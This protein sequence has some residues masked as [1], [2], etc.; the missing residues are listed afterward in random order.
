MSALAPRILFDNPDLSALAAPAFLLADLLAG[1]FPRKKARPWEDVD[2][3]LAE[4]TRQLDHLA[5]GLGLDPVE[6]ALLRLAVLTTFVA[7]FAQ[8][9]DRFRARSP[10]R[11]SAALATALDTRPSA[12]DAALRPGGLL[13]TVLSVQVTTDKDA[14]SLAVK[15]YDLLGSA[16]SV[17]AERGG[18]LFDQLFPELPAATLHVEA[19]AWLGD[20]LELLLRTLRGA[21]HTGACGAS[22]LLVG[23]P[24]TGK[25]Q[26]ARTVVAALGARGIQIEARTPR[27]SVMG[28]TERL[29]CWQAAQRAFAAVPGTV[30]V[31]D[32]AEDAFLALD[33]ATDAEDRLSKAGFNE[34]LEEARVPTIWITNTVEDVDPAFLRRFLVRLDVPV[35]PVEV[36]RALAAA[37]LAP[38][39][40]DPALVSGLAAL[41]TTT[42]AEIDRAARALALAAPSEDREASAFARVLLAPG[43][44]GQADEAA[45]FEPDWLEV[46][47]DLVALAD[48]LATTGAG[49]LLLQ[50]PPGTG[51]TAFGGWLAARLGRPLHRLP[52]SAALDKYVG[53]TEKNLAQ[54]FALAEAVGAVLLV[55]EVDGLF[56]ARRGGE[57]AWHSTQIA[58]ALTLLERFNGLFVATTNLPGSLDPAFFRRFDLTIAVPAPGP[59]RRARMVGALADELGLPAPD[60]RDLAGLTPGLVAQA[61]RRWGL[62]GAPTT[63]EALRAALAAAVA[64]AT[65]SGSRPMGFAVS[66]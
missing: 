27:G 54:A 20:R 66:P 53:G 4:L 61:K 59:E 34:A 23:P 17:W 10:A 15:R 30:V 56:A 55:D 40:V 43:E 14:A 8:D 19:Y 3:E 5:T 57:P 7:P 50:G 31:F 62:V 45:R 37:R 2:P 21:L 29:S 22:A 1:E 13:K 18:D 33:K 39:G 46:D 58:E 28:A 11:L 65:P 35:A 49:R 26:L 25:S 63:S 9:P 36:R 64:S 60:V 42:P 48:R 51:K 44:R 52:P 16:L 47:V 38:L 41:P 32:E 6:A 24:G 12:I